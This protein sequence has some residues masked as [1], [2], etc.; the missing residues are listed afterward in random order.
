MKARDH[1]RKTSTNGRKKRTTYDDL[2]REGGE[3]TCE[4]VAVAQHLMGFV[5][6]RKGNTIKQI[7]TQSGARISQ[8]E[9]H[10]ATGFMVCG[11]KEERT[12]AI[13]LVNRKVAEAHPQE[14][15]RHS[16]PGQLVEIP[17]QFKKL[18]N[19]PGGDN[20]RSVSTITGAEVTR[21][22]AHRFYVSGDKKKAQHAEFLLRRKVASCRVRCNRICN[23]ID[24]RN[25][26][27]ECDFKLVPLEGRKRMILP[28]AQ[29]QYHLRP[30]DEYE[31]Q[32]QGACKLNCEANYDA[33][34][35]ENALLALHE[36]KQEI[37]SKNFHKADMW[38]HFG[39]VVIHDPDEADVEDIWSFTEAA[40][41]LQA[42]S[43]KRNEWRAAFRE[44]MNLNV[45]V[46]QDT[47]GEPTEEDFMARYDLTFLSPRSQSI[48]CKVWVARKGVKKK[49][50]DIP[51]PFSDLKNVV[52]E[53][54][55]EDEL[56][57]ARCRGWLVL[58]SQKF[59]Q[60]DIISPGCKIDCRIIIR[61]LTDDI[62]HKASGVHEREATHLLSRYLSK[63]TFT[64]AAGLVFPNEDLPQGYIFSHRRCSRRTQYT[65]RLGFSMIVSR[66]KTW[67]SDLKD[68][69]TRET[70]DIHLGTEEWDR[71]LTGKEWEPEMI[72]AKLPDFL[73]FVREV[74]D[75]ISENCENET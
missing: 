43:K 10:H 54:H 66:E 73:H 18:V 47:F 11:S 69:E 42:T 65:P 37:C 52:E 58:Q 26:P 50:E 34:L 63:L 35:M 48:R 40:Q 74:Q 19:G 20:L 72:V 7:Q 6:G 59:L 67:C 41:K 38:C 3:E 49:L 28:G 9:G 68:E 70:T 57:R 44:G 39:T 45:K 31:I 1:N 2:R 8:S 71:L 24:K 30:A 15:R 13:E 16:S 51:I 14:T 56:T 55:F 12:C 53:L 29:S 61:A 33:S 17:S 64:D 60:A 46:L 62:I 27:E 4:F 22:V 25:L 23:Y 36:I 5:I 75:F 21:G 32:A